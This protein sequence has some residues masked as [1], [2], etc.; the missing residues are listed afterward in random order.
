MVRVMTHL[1]PKPRKAEAV[2]PL[3][4]GL[5]EPG[6]QEDGRLRYELRQDTKDPADLTS[7]EEW[8]S[9]W[10]WWTSARV[11]PME[12]SPPAPSIS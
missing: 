9:A 10:P 7:I 6:R 12:V 2:K 1:P 4:G 5:V 11:C 3:P 8:A